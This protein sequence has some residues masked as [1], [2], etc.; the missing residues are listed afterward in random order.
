MKSYEEYLG[1]E[2]EPADCERCGCD[3][4][5]VHSWREGWL[6]P[7]VEHDYRC[8]ECGGPWEASEAER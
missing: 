8:E 3:I 6:M 5:V 2:H 7:G 1:D 4:V